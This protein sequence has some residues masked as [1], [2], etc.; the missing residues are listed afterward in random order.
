[1]SL[2]YLKL[3]SPIQLIHSFGSSSPFV[4]MWYSTKTTDVLRFRALASFVSYR[5]VW[6]PWSDL[7]P[8]TTLT[9]IRYHSSQEWTERQRRDPYVKKAKYL[10]YRARSAF[11]LLEINGKYRILRPGHIVVDL[12]AA[13][14]S[15][16]QVAVQAVNASNPDE[17]TS[18]AQDPVMTIKLRDGEQKLVSSPPLRKDL[19]LDPLEKGMVVG[20]DLLHINPLPGAIFLSQSDFTTDMIQQALRDALK[21]REVDVVMSDM[22]PNASGIREMDHHVIVYLCFAALKFAK[23]VLAENGTF[24]CKAWNGRLN[25]DLLSEMKKYFRSARSVKPPA[26]RDDSSEVY[27]LATGYRK[28]NRDVKYLLGFCAIVIR[29]F[30]RHLPALFR[31]DCSNKKKLLYSK[32][33]SSE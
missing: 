8:P 10:S 31:V 24:L 33:V 1:M 7:Y 22:A 12:G 29:S 25:D 3:R 18:P 26:S 6:S 2:P 28:I 16:S 13:P 21:G 23:E 19:K 20:V 11:K 30:G 5:T 4:L 14:G 9:T 17:V 27:F 15:W 32:K